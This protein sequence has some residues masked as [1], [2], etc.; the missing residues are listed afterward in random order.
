ML[1]TRFPYRKV[2]FIMTVLVNQDKNVLHVFSSCRAASYWSQVEQGPPDA[3]FGLLEAFNK[4]PNPSKVSLVA[5]AYRD[6]E[7]K[8]Y[9][10]PVVRK[11]TPVTS[12]KRMHVKYT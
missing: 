9:V 1:E 2:L 10:L 4:D 3:I 6:N 12:Q 11:V 7:G 8:P 5:G